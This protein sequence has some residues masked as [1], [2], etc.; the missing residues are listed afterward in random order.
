MRSTYSKQRDISDNRR[1][2]QSLQPN[3]PV[4]SESRIYSPTDSNE[5]YA[6]DSAPDRMSNTQK[7]RL[8]IPRARF[9]SEVI[10]KH[11]GGRK[12]LSAK[13]NTLKSPGRMRSIKITV[14]SRKG[15]LRH[16]QNAEHINK[17]VYKMNKH[18]LTNM[19]AQNKI[20]KPDSKAPVELMQHIAKHVFTM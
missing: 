19:L 5:A 7:S 2:P 15:R 9:S 17:S 11:R 13:R 4:T 18:S 20:I 16:T 6:Q 8:N 14:L 10:T 1:L 3:Q 12:K